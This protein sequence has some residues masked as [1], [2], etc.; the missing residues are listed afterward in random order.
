L[1]VKEDASVFPNFTDVTLV[2]LFPLI[3]TLVPVIPE[4]GVNDLMIGFAALKIN[5]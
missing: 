3:V 5:V 4:A 1:I 2:K